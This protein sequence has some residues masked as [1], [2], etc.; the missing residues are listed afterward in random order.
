[1]KE[2]RTTMKEYEKFAS[3]SA[4]MAS[5]DM[6]WYLKERCCPQTGSKCKD[7]KKSCVVYCWLK[8]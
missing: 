5:F 6:S 2:S 7:V 4:M 1:M 3:P 8:G